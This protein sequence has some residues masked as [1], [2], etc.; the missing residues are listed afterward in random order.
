LIDPFPD[1]RID[2]F[3]VGPICDPAKR[4]QHEGGALALA[5]LE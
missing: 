5:V 2:D 4:M 3:T 1:R